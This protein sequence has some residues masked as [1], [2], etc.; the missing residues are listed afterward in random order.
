MIIIYHTTRPTIGEDINLMLSYS[1]HISSYYHHIYHSKL[2]IIGED[3]NLMLSYYHHISYQAAY[4]WR[5]YQLNAIIVSSYIII[6]SA[7]HHDRIII[8]H[9]KRS[10]IGKDINL[11]LSYSH[12]ISYQASYNYLGYTLNAVIFSSLILPSAL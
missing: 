1:H 4:N 12:H 2:F 9:T 3:I 6:L 10:I 7:Y 8:Y 5:G 11:M